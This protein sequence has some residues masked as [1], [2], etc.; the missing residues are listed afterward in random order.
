MLAG[1]PLQCTDLASFSIL[2][3]SGCYLRRYHWPRPLH[4]NG[5]DWWE[6]CSSE[7]ICSIW[8]VQVPY[9]LSIPLWLPLFPLPWLPL[10]PLP[11]LPLFPLPWL[12]LFPLPW[13]PLF[14]LAFLSHYNWWTGLPHLCFHCPVS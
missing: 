4:C 8:Y 7:D 12:P 14:P 9:S 3:P 13:L 10:F 6:H 11:W 1:M 2:E 5:C